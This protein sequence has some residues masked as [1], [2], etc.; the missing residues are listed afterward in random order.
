LTGK[1]RALQKV[2]HLP[3][4]TIICDGTLFHFIFIRRPW[5]G[6]YHSCC[7]LPSCF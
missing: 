1:K 4:E 5:G 6:L 7:S 3:I 2:S